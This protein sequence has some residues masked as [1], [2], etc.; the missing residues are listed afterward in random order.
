MD[1]SG[2]VSFLP[3]AALAK[4][5]VGLTLDEVETGAGG[6]AVAV[7]IVGDV[8]SPLEEVV[9]ERA[10]SVGPGRGR[11]WRELWRDIEC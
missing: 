1:A 3:A 7:V 8:T 5:N 9:G 2:A 4:L 6:V 11:A 10:L